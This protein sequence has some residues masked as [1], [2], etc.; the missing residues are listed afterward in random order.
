ML[1]S[2]LID[3]L[4]NCVAVVLAHLEREIAPAALRDLSEPRFKGVSIYRT[5]PTGTLGLTTPRSRPR[6]RESDRRPARN[7]SAR[8]GTGMATS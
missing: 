2:H 6:R 3:L 8:T 5:D 1:S 4:N 7:S